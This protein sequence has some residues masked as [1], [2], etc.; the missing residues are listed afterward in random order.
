M[1]LEDS[2]IK[3]WSR[4]GAFALAIIFTSVFLWLVSRQYLT[5]QVQAPDVDQF[6]QA[7]WNTLRGRFLFTTITNN[8]ILEYHFSPYM[9][10]LSPLLLVWEDVRILFLAQIISIAATG[11]IFYKMVEEKSPIAAVLFLLAFYLNAS[12][13][14]IGLLELRRVTLAMPFVALALYGLI[15]DKRWLMMAGIILTLLVKEDLG[16]IVA[17]IGLYLLVIKRDWKWGLPIAILGVAWSLSMVL[18]IIPALRGGNYNQIGYFSEWGGTPG[19]IV[20][21]IVTDPLQV[22]QVMFDEKGRD[23]LWRT[24][25]PMAIILPFLAADLL[26]IG[27][28]LLI[29]MLLSSEPEMHA[30]QRWYLAP[31]LPVLF[32]A[33]AVAI[34]RVPR[35]YVKWIIVL[36]LGMTI[37]SFFLYSPAPLGGQ[38]QPHL[39]Q[40]TERQ[41]RAWDVVNEIPEDAKVAS[42]VAFIAH[43][44]QREHIYLYPW[45]AIGK[46]NI[47]YFMLGRDFRAYPYKTEDIVWEINN[48]VA[49]PDM[50]IEMEV[51][52]IYLIRQGGPQLPAVTMQRLAEDSILLDRA[53]IAV[54]DEKG[55][56][57]TLDKGLL[58]LSPGQEVRV[59]LYWEALDRVNGERTVS[60]RIEDSS[61]ALVAQ[62]DMLP[63]DGSR[64]TSWWEPGWR[65]RDVYYLNVAPVVAPGPAS[66]DV[67]LYDSFTQERIEFDGGDDIIHILP[68][69]FIASQEGDES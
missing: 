27:L 39:Y 13:H 59:T 58:T 20:K 16:L 19:E 11:L 23:G 21:N 35:R 34:N 3:L 47:D 46:E 4:W 26:M 44:A 37:I 68:V 63:G 40:I 2:R 65:F 25:L 41:L 28:P 50:V 53:E 24:F 42:Q 17:A 49:D 31:V 60:V 36:L 12:L 32:A 8:S 61:G 1:T 69:N 57:R 45:F 7:I 10:F 5:F 22:L 66:L 55:I 67:V 18:W 48:L 15:K 30:L 64:P 52:G 51:D 6:D 9:A 29:L 43:L 14:Q 62:H 33:V 54:A 38:Y 56:Y